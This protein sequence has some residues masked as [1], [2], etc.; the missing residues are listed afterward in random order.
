MTADSIRRMSFR[1]LGASTLAL[2]ACATGDQ[3]PLA[4]AAPALEISGS[5]CEPDAIATLRDAFG[6][7]IGR[8]TFK[9][10]GE[11]TLVAIDAQLP[12][13]QGASIHGIHIHANDNPDNGEGCVADP[14]QAASTHFTSVDGHWSPDGGHHGQH[15]G[16]LPAIFFTRAGEA[17]MRFLT[18]Q[19]QAE[20]LFGRALILHVGPDNYGNVPVGEEPHQYTANDPSALEATA[21]TGNAGARIACGVIE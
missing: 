17:S 1:V 19:F 13:E 18:D 20:Q 8:V 14:E 21:N 15:S 11:T 7:A 10:D 2:A 6:T 12:V 4:G 16:D 9:S 3:E 5:C